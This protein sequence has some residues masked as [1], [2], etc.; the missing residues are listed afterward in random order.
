MRGLEPQFIGSPIRSL[1]AVLAE[2]SQ[3]PLKKAQWTESTSELYRPSDRRLSAKLVPTFVDR[4]CQVVRFTNPY[5]RILGFLDR[6]RY[7]FFQV[8]PQLYLRG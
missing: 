5:G 8:A 2:L 7:F 4:G 6:S 1:V 3:F